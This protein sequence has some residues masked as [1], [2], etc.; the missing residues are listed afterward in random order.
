VEGFYKLIAS[1]LQ[2]EL[3]LD[4]IKASRPEVV[5][6]LKMHGAKLASELTD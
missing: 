1:N 4:R 2:L 3:D 5:E 6:L